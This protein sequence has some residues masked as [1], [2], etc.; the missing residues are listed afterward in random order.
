M[1]ARACPQGKIRKHLDA[2][3]SYPELPGI[4]KDLDW[5]DHKKRFAKSCAREAQGPSAK[6]KAKG[7]AKPK[8][9]PNRSGGA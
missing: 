1:G 3:T 2:S 7:K 4:Q 9:G 6:G 8:P 5:W